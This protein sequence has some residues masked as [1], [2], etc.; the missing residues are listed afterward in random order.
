MNNNIDQ[1]P[2]GLIELIADDTFSI[3]SRAESGGGYDYSIRDIE[4]IGS[5]LGIDPLQVLVLIAREIGNP[6]FS[7]GTLRPYHELAL[8]TTA[9][10]D[11]R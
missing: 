11:T 8:G 10:P 1:R 3:Q 5:A 6:S 4:N 9:N 7:Y 2:L